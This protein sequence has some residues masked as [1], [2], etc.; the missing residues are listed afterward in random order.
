MLL[1]NKKFTIFMTLCFILMTTGGF[2]CKNKTGDGSASPSITPSGIATETTPS[3]APSLPVAPQA[4]DVV[5][6][7]I[8]AESELRTLAR[9]FTEVWG[10]FSSADNCQNIK[11][12]LDYMSGRFRA[13]SEGIIEE[14]CAE[15]YS[16]LPFEWKTMV[17]ETVVLSQEKKQAKILAVTE[18]TIQ[19]GEVSESHYAN[20][21]LNLVVETNL[22]GQDEWRVDRASWAD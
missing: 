19:R 10:T 22:A 11:A 6:E 1:K 18:R 7:G 5:D 12:L 3:S 9:D 16:G 20:L 17:L 2:G 14:Q 21:L 15:R 4:V 13:E 8:N